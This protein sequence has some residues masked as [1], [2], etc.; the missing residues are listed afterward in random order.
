MRPFSP[1]DAGSFHGREAEITELIGRLR[2]GQR[3]IFVIG[4]SGSGKSS[5]VAAGVLPRLAHGLS[6]LGP[7]VVRELRPGAQPFSRLCQLL[8][9][10]LA[11]PLAA[12]ERIAALLAHRAPGALALVV[13]DQLEELF[14][15]ANAEERERFLDGLR[16]LRTE[17]RCVVI[18]TLRADFSGALMESPLWPERPVQ[19][20][21]IEVT[22]LR[23]T[24]LREAIA[25]PAEA[26]GVT[27]EPELIE[28]LVA[29]TA[30]EP[31]I[32]PLLQ[33]TLVQLWDVRAD[34][35]LTLASY[36]ALGDGVRSGLAVALARRA[37]ATLQR[38]NAAQTDIPRRI[39]PL[40]SFGEG[41]SDT[42]RQ[43]PRAQ[44][45]AAGEDAADFDRVLQTM[46]DHRLLTVDDD[47][48]GEPRVD[49]AHEIMISA[50]PTLAGWIRNHR[51]DEQRRRQL[52]A[53]AAAWA[54]HGRTTRGL[55]DPIELAD[56]EQ[57]QQTES[58]VQL[59]RSADVVALIA[60]SRTAQHKQ[61]RR[62][63]L[64]VSTVGLLGLVAAVAAAVAVTERGQTKEA[65]RLENEARRSADEARHAENEAR[66][67]ADKNRE[68]VAQSYAEAG[69]Q[70]VVDHRHQEA[71][72]YLL[73]ARERGVESPPLRMMFG[74]GERHVPLAPPL[75]HQ[76][77]VWS[78]AFSPDGTRV[79]TASWDK[80]AR[81]WDAATGKPLTSALEHQ[82]VVVSAAFSP[83][84]TRVF[85]AS[86]DKTARVWDVRS[87]WERSPNGP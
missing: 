16:A 62:R 77:T 70:L 58:A 51:V 56:A 46:V 29:D 15:Q 82:D 24:A 12:T 42:R 75:E 63:R 38:F 60:A 73:A 13:V 40:I 34:Q 17:P 66:R 11:Q 32:L 30:A 85:T 9:A 28:R 21:R 67:L 39:L 27:V 65:R 52:E 49:L 57:W 84:G 31:G 48:D 1:D 50:W 55:L 8:D 4:P 47:V 20:S 83:E 18:C 7:F 3:E 79:V 14:T 26:I 43:Q 72:P 61:R 80:T 25:A 71:V 33:E 87:R 45:R 69:R 5:L 59:G 54:D 35:T 64:V 44:L 68:L 2:A 10:P 36:Q 81:M 86:W 53:A 74:E 19:L 41:R 76:A 6:G 23:G 37:D 22:P 78:A